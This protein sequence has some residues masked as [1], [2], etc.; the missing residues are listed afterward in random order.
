MYLKSLEGETL[1][2]IYLHLFVLFATLCY[3]YNNLDEHTRKLNR[4]MDY[5]LF[6]YS[7]Y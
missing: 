4:V 6:I 3:H 1:G 7:G 2:S 5:F